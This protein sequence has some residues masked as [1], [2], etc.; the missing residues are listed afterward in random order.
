ML[1]RT[2]DP[3][4]ARY[5]IQ[6][7]DQILPI[8]ARHQITENNDQ[9][10]RRGCLLALQIDNELFET[11]ASI[12]PIG[13]RDQMRILS[14][15]ARDANIT[16]PLFTNDGFEEGG[17][18]PGK[19]PN[20]WSK[21]P[22]GIDLYGFDKYV[23]FAPS[24]SPK[25]WLI[26]GGTKS[27][28]WKDWNPKQME[29]SM[30]KLEKTVRGFG[31]GAKESPMFIP[32]LQGGWFNHYQLE[33]TYDQIYDYYGDQYTK[34][35]VESSLAQGVT[36]ISLY[37]V[38][39]GTN[40][41]TLGDPDVYTSYDYSA[42]IREFGY[43]SSR[44][45]NLRQ[46]LLFTQSFEP[47]FTRTALL[48]KSTIKPSVKEILNRQRVAVGADQD[49]VFTF[50]RNFDRKQRSDFEITVKHGSSTF[51]MGCHFDYKTSFI[52]V[53]NY[54]TINGL[55]LIQATIPI[56]ARMIH[57]S[58]K[59]EIWIVEP[60]SK[61]GLAFENNVPMTVTGDMQDD[62]NSKATS[63]TVSLI[64]FNKAEGWMKLA[65]DNGVLHI[66]GLAAGDVSTLYGDFASPYWNQGAAGD[67]YPGLLAWGADDLYYNRETKSLQVGHNIHDSTLH[68][69]S[70]TKPTD[71][72]LILHDTNMPHLYTKTLA[73][74]ALEQQQ[75]PVELSLTH[76][77]ER[78]VDWASLDWQPLM[79]DSKNTLIW[80][81]IDYHFTSGHVLYRNTF[82]T[83]GQSEPHV[84]LSLN[85]RHRATVLMNGH[86]VGGH[87]TYSRQLFSTGAKIGPD[88]WF[89]GTQTYDLSPYLVREG[90]ELMNTLV[91]LV[92]SFGLAR[93]AFI[94]NDIR[95]PRGIIK[96]KLH[97]VDNGKE[98]AQT[99]EISGVDVRSIS[100]PFNSTGFPD[101]QQDQG[102]SDMKPTMDHLSPK[103]SSSSS[104]SS[105]S[106]VV[107]TGQQTYRMTLEP[108]QGAVW[109]RFEFDNPWKKNDQQRVP[110]R[111]RLDGEQ[112]A[113]VILND[114][115]IGLYYGN[116]DGPQH[117]FYL[118]EELV[119]S[120]GNVI[121]MLVYT[122]VPTEVHVSIVGWHVKVPGSGN[123][124]TSS[125]FSS[126]TSAK[127]LD[128]IVWKDTVNIQ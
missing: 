63:D 23:V 28:D 125:D 64:Q 26:D 122:W 79:R 4:F 41:G 102:F 76:W 56:H 51:P 50:F 85:A 94:M 84:K 18:V 70:F 77:Q 13:L 31:G 91:V 3:D 80:N 60:N 33:H 29:N 16:V 45:R 58:T 62:T 74:H 22:F 126:E 11:M 25:S 53:G 30:D 17:W 5:E 34:L 128:Y 27:G 86:I 71:Q 117:D 78:P 120:Q 52:A 87:A 118:P 54:R 93:Q 14:K 124:L 88:P 121:R 109:W 65:T 110:L 96:A 32:E 95:N 106:D 43:L 119:K 38:Y 48:D 47:Y 98:L 59:E 114:L 15:A 89:L 123:L 81:A 105:I 55:H 1:W 19:I 10:R 97:G 72:L 35:L 61:G 111:L 6:W 73:D 90:R 116:G 2:Y 40:W 57:P 7:L 103:T 42:C 108:T 113:K 115:L 12:L 44:G 99:W 68:V 20:F 101:E 83:P 112:T 104:T 69:L 92:D 21:Y 82:K 49:V 8:L 24:S 67:W 37:M 75:N 127:P 36:M 100:Q 9:R 46:T 66:V 39:G 107:S